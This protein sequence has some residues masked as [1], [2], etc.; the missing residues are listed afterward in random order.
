[1]FDAVIPEYQTYTCY[2]AKQWEGVA[3]S[4]EANRLDFNKT[5]TVMKQNGILVCN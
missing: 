1:M 5:T 4:E 2:T 3:Q